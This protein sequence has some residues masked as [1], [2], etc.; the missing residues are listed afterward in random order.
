MQEAS[1]QN[2]I[3]NGYSIWEMEK[4]NIS[5][6]LLRKRLTIFEYPNLNDKV[7]VVTYPI[8]S[9]RILAFRETNIIKEVIYH[10]RA[11]SFYN[12]ILTAEGEKL[13][14]EN[15]VYRIRNKNKG[16]DIAFASIVWQPR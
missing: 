5:W 12:D 2:S 10:I 1:M 7:R 3:E 4:D 6:V 13:S 11:E 15:I 8:T 16:T 14:D 9:K